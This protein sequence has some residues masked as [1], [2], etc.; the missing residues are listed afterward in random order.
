VSDFKNLRVWENARQLAFMI[1]KYTSEF[2]KEEVYGLT[3]QIRRAAISISSNIAEGKGRNT[4]NELRRF[5]SIAE[6]SRCELESLLIIS[7]DLGFISNEKYNAI[8]KECQ[9]IG[10]SLGKLISILPEAG[11]R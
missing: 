8:I 1:Y 9:D 5:C 7:K 3:S 2:P 6:G 4:D 11:S 10:R